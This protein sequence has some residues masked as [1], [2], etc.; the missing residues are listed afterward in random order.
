M[1]ADTRMTA[2]QGREEC[3]CVLETFRTLTAL[4]REG[5]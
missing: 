1:T 4:E 3:A 5:V 2:V